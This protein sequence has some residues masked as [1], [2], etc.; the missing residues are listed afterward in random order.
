MIFTLILLGDEGLLVVITP[1][2]GNEKYIRVLELLATCI[3]SS[4]NGVVLIYLN[5]MF[6][7][8][9]MFFM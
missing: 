4:K 7:C 2:Q 6:L 9:D 3:S 5:F 1:L 8:R